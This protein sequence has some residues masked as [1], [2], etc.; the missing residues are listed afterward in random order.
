MAK[1]LVTLFKS[2]VNLKSQFRQTEGLAASYQMRIYIIT[3][4]HT[5]NRA[6]ST[7]SRTVEIISC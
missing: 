4:F 1:V 5:K 7:L 6:F 2:Q 3:L